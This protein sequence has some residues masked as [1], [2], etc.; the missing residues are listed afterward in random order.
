MTIQDYLHPD[1]HVS[2]TYEMTPGLKPF[3]LAFFPSGTPFLYE[4]FLRELGERVYCSRFTIP[5]NIMIKRLCDK[6]CNKTAFL[7]RTIA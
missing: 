7:N 2:R 3:I 6:V 4:L 5:G 1:D